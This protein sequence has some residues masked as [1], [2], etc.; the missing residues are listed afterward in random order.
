MEPQSQSQTQTKAELEKSK[1]E[2]EK[3]KTTTTTTTVQVSDDVSWNLVGSMLNG[4]D[5]LTRHQIDSFNNF[6]HIDLPEIFKRYNPIIVAVDYNETTDTFQRQCIVKFGNV[7]IGR[8]VIQENYHYGNDTSVGYR[9]LYPREARLRH[10]TYAAPV[11][12]DVDWQYIN[13]NKPEENTSGLESKILLFRLPIMIGSDACYLGGDHDSLDKEVYDDNHNIKGYFVVGGGEKVIVSQERHTDNKISVYNRP[14][15]VVAEIK[16]SIDQRFYPIKVARVVLTNDSTLVLVIGSLK[17]NIPLFLVLR[18]FGLPNDFAIYSTILENLEEAPVNYLNILYETTTVTR[19]VLLREHFLAENEGLNPNNY[20]P[21]SQA[22]ALYVVGRKYLGLKQDLDGGGGNV[23]ASDDSKSAK[24]TGASASAGASARSAEQDRSR[25]ERSSFYLHQIRD[26]INREVLQ[27]VGQNLYNKGMFLCLMARRLLD[28]AHGRRPYDNRDHYINKRLN[29]AGYLMSELFRGEFIKLTKQLKQN[30]L[31]FLKNGKETN[32]SLTINKHIRSSNMEP[33][34]KYALSTGNW[35]SNKVSNSSKGISQVLQRI[36]YLSTL[37]HTRRIQSP[38]D[39][40]G[41]KITPPRHLHGTQ[42]GFICANETPEGAQVGMVKNLALSCLVTIDAL[43]YK[44]RIALKQLSMIEVDKMLYGELKNGVKV[45][46]NGE[47]VGIFTSDKV[48]EAFVNLK[49]LK[50]FGVINPFISVSWQIEWR[51]LYI[52]TDGG[53]YTRPLLRVNLKDNQLVFLKY[54]DTIERQQLLFERLKSREAAKRVDWL[55]L[56]NCNWYERLKDE[57]QFGWWREKGLENPGCLIEYLDTGEIETS[58]ISDS[59]SNFLDKTKGT[60]AVAGAGAGAT[61]APNCQS[62]YIHRYTHCEIHPV[63]MLGIVGGLIPYSDHNP[64]PRNCYQCLHRD[65]LVLMADQ[66]YRCIA[67]IK[68]GD[69][70]VSVDPKTHQTRITTVTHQYVRTTE[71]N[72]VKIETDDH[73]TLVCTDDHPILTPTGWIAAGQL[74]SG[75]KV[76]VHG[77]GNADNGGTR[78]VCEAT[79]TLIEPHPNVEIADISVDDDCHSFIT[80][81]GIVVHN[82][83]MGKQA[84][85]I[86]SSGYHER[87][88]TN[89]HVLMYGHRPLVESRV[90]KYIGIDDNPHGGEIIVAFL[91]YTGYNVED[92]VIINESSVERGLFNTLFFR[93]YKD[94][95]KKHRSNTL[96]SEKFGFPPGFK[97]DDPSTVPIMESQ[98]GAPRLDSVAMGDFHIIGKYTVDKNDQFIESKT[99]MARHSEFGVIDLIFKEGTN[100]K[101]GYPLKGDQPSEHDYIPNRSNE[102]N[103]IIK[104]RLAQARQPRIG[105][106]F[107]SRCA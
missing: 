106:K 25:E 37:S 83:S 80:G 62:G 29:T 12:V 87:F 51:E 76:M 77:N 9:P 13:N 43:D 7:Y 81:Q 47:W 79:I 5:A 105:D 90:S 54:F 101:V 91:T 102:D 26:H 31:T 69:Q 85:S 44:V 22:F 19:Q 17:Q 55:D 32:L 49:K 48:K 97:P 103:R 73:R 6:L 3:S 34:F 94:E 24:G 8:P 15:L 86:Y 71:K 45:F 70:V 89:S 27:H 46:I 67:E 58:L 59:L 36:S 92:S 93:S 30:L 98:D 66:T 99:T 104:V 40:S 61:N 10:L 64:A 68:I 4:K 35:A 57:P 63:L 82:S 65:E 52:Q 14:P 2:L 107:A 21:F 42:F 100:H 84:I 50:H 23:G 60:G 28:V 18:A 16:S 75:Y 95:E 1:A 88:D 74:Q 11:F 53:R 33:R 38:I 78:E 56:I 39:S 41:Q 72:I 96:S 20:G